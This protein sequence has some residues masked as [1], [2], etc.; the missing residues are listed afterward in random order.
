LGEAELACTEEKRQAQDDFRDI[1]FQNYATQIEL[2]SSCSN[3]L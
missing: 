3:P 1:I 2:E